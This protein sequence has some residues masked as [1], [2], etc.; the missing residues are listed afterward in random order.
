MGGREGEGMIGGGKG[1]GRNDW[2]GEGGLVDVEVS[3][4][5][6][7]LELVGMMGSYFSGGD[8]GVWV[9]I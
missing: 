6:G 7:G 5:G 9:F 1:G 4:G 3:V 2:W 8:G